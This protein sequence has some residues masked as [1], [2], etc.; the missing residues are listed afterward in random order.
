ML[1]SSLFIFITC[2][3]RIFQACRSLADSSVIRVLC[4][5]EPQCIDARDS[6]KRVPLHYLIKNYTTFGDDNDDIPNIDEDDEEDS[7][8]K[9]SD[10]G[11]D[12]NVNSDEDGMTA[13]LIII[14]SNPNCLNA[15]DH[16]GWLPLHVACSCSSRKGMLR[17][18]R[19]LL[20]VKPESI[21]SKTDKKSDVFDCVNMAGKHHPTKDETIAILKEA[22]SL[23]DDEERGSAS[24]DTGDNVSNSSDSS[25][26]S[27]ISDEHDDNSDDNGD[28]DDSLEDSLSNPQAQV[29]DLLLPDEEALSQKQFSKESED[30]TESSRGEL[31]KEAHCPEAVLINI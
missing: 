21:N 30:R 23:V 24:E 13:M 10:S 22:K 4:E 2:Q 8:T 20:K 14:K 26:S 15:A 31:P 7:D 6:L 12:T 5:M 1:I 3:T 28:E 16:R 9:D 25:V 27:Q 19:L 17:V 29:V 11:D 18:L